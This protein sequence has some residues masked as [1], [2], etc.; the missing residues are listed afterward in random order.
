MSSIRSL[1]SWGILLSFAL[2]APVSLPAGGIDG[3]KNEIRRSYQSCDP[4]FVGKFCQ[5]RLIPYSDAPTLRT[6]KPGTFLR[7]IRIWKDYEGNNWL[8]VQISSIGFIENT[9]LVT[10]G[11][12]NV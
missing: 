11:W 1:F 12:L 2:F 9:G 6:L 3:G 7:V 5:L 8:K 4:I 10:R